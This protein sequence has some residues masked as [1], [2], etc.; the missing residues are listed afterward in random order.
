MPVDMSLDMTLEVWSLVASVVSVVISLIAIGLSLTFYVHGN[1]ANNTATQTLAKVETLVST[2]Q[3]H[4]FGM[5]EQTI[6]R[7]SSGASPVAEEI[8]SLDTSQQAHTEQNDDKQGS[9]LNAEADALSRLY[10]AEMQ[11]NNPMYTAVFGLIGGAPMVQSERERIRALIAIKRAQ[12]RKGY[13][14]SFDSQ[15]QPQDLTEK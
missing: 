15:T 9:A 13:G 11:L 10:A 7:I 4:A 1:R 12:L 5:L 6:A 14:V 3:Q 8:V 2:I